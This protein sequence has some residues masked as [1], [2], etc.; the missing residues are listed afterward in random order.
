M[1]GLGVFLLPPKWDATPVGERHHES[2]G[3]FPRAQC[4]VPVQGGNP[5]RSAPESS[6]GSLR[7]PRDS[8]KSLQI[9]YSIIKQLIALKLTINLVCSRKP[10][11]FPIH[12]RLL[13]Y[14]ILIAFW[15]KL[16]PASVAWW[17]TRRPPKPKIEA[18]S[19][20]RGVSLSS[21]F[22]P[23]YWGKYFQ[24]FYK[25]ELKRTPGETL[26]S[27]TALGRLQHYKLRIALKSRN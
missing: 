20:V 17:I 10:T 3:S 22:P 2:K 4:N 19:P 15:S 9:F 8:I 16:T 1:K 27:W 23:S 25:C 26:R 11:K 7:P 18:S 21:F 14:Y 6:A 12:C 5:D 13:N 24:E